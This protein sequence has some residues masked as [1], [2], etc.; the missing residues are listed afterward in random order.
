M[1]TEAG[2]TSGQLIIH[3]KHNTSIND[4]YPNIPSAIKS[5]QITDTQGKWVYVE[6][7]IDLGLIHNSGYENE[8]LRI[9]CFPENNTPNKYMLVDDIRFQPVDATMMTYNYDKVTWKLT[10]ITDQNNV[11]SYFEYDE[12]GRL[13][14]IKNDERKVL[15]A[16]EYK[17][18]R[19]Q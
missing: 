5:V 7:V 19:T 9:R 1:K 15:S 4:V 11:S 12:A 13:T 6:G 14:A 16:Y 8:T 17:H 2:F 10:S 18:G 3:S